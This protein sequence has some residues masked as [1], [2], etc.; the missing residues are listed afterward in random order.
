M[1]PHEQTQGLGIVGR[2]YCSSL[3]ER[4]GIRN[5][6]EFV[7]IMIFKNELMRILVKAQAY[8]LFL[9]NHNNYSLENGKKI[10]IQYLFKDVNAT[11]YFQYNILNS[12]C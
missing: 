5:S 1:W 10:P 4:D 3:R 6:A 9:Q 2:R 7:M 11:R 12:Q 8:G